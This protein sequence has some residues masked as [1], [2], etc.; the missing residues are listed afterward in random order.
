[1]C[2]HSGVRGAHRRGARLHGG[3]LP[4]RVRQTRPLRQATAAGKPLCHTCVT[5]VS[6]LGHACV[7]PVSR[8]CYACVTPVL[9]LWHACGTPVFADL[10]L[11]N[12]Y[13]TS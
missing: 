4:R 13:N 6:H 5:P 2:G 8:L 9:R 1:M 11:L 12:K 7:T 3:L 10:C